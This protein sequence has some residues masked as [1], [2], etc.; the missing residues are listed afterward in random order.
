MLGKKV[1]G[2]ASIIAAGFSGPEGS[3][4]PRFTVN[5][6]SGTRGAGTGRSVTPPFR[7]PFLHLIP[8]TP[9]SANPS[10]TICPPLFH[11]SPHSIL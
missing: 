2:D 3:W 6:R 4:D 7:T 10:E 8:P 11:L 1:R 5:P 9:C